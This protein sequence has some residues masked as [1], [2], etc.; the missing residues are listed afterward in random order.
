MYDI[1][2]QLSLQKK[3]EVEQIFLMLNTHATP[4]LTKDFGNSC[5][6]ELIAISVLEED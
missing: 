3:T 6:H 5:C 4:E 1:I 2:D